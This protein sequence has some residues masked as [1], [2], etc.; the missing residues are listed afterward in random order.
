MTDNNLQQYINDLIEFKPTTRKMT[1]I[2]N[3]YRVNKK[4]TTTINVPNS[5]Y[6]QQKLPMLVLIQE[7]V[8][9]LDSNPENVFLPKYLRNRMILFR[10]LKII[11]ENEIKTLF[12]KKMLTKL[13]NSK[14]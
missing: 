3:D 2:R 13:I 6:Q 7:L 5:F 4:Y 10:L 8:N 14:L 12:K 9:I 1:V 11:E